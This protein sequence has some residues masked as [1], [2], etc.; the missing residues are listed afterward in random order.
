MVLR[1]PLAALRDKVGVRS[2]YPLSA[3]SCVFVPL[4]GSFAVNYFALMALDGFCTDPNLKP[5]LVRVT[6]RVRLGFRL[7][8]G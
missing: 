2:R 5:A 4:S 3:S 6:V 8:L 1:G 7:Q